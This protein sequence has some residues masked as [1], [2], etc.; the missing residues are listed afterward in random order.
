MD[1]YL[2]LTK[3]TAR[4]RIPKVLFSLK[5]IKDTGSMLPHWLTNPTMRAV[6]SFIGEFTETLW[7]WE[8]W[9]IGSIGNLGA[10]G[11][12]RSIT[13]QHYQCRWNQQ[14]L[15]L[16][17]RVPVPMGAAEGLQECL[18]GCSMDAAS[19]RST[20]RKRKMVGIKH[21]LWQPCFWEHETPFRAL[22]ISGWGWI[23][24]MDW[25]S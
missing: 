12:L 6:F 11:P 5:S 23:L 16:N 13:S 14:G 25:K 21:E 24:K 17:G 19:F 22:E 10:S 1:S 2:K 8:C 7:S 9:L 4:E 15:T 18:H 3:K 20:G